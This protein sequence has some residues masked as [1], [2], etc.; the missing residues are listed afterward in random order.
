MSQENND[1]INKIGGWR[2]GAVVLLTFVTTVASSRGALGQGASDGES[3]SA[4]PPFEPAAEAS[5]TAETNP[6]SEALSITVI[7][8]KGLVQARES[9]DQPWRPATEGLQVT[10]GAEFRTG[11]RSQVV[12]FIA[13]DQTVAL[14]RLGTIKVIEAIRDDEKVK[15][16]LGMKYGRSVYDVEA[17]GVEHEAKIHMPGQTLSICG[18]RAAVFNQRPFPPQTTM[19]EGTGEHR[20][21]RRGVRIRAAAL[22][23]GRSVPAAATAPLAASVPR[24][25]L[26]QLRTL[27]FYDLDEEQLAIFTDLLNDL[28]NAAGIGFSGERPNVTV[29]SEQLNAL[30]LALQKG[31]NTGGSTYGL[32]VIEGQLIVTYPS[33]I[34][35]GLPGFGQPQAPDMVSLAASRTPGELLFELDW[36][37]TA[38]L[39]FG[40]TSPGG[41]KYCPNPAGAI[42]GCELSFDANLIEISPDAVGGPSTPH[43]ESVKFKVDHANGPYNVEVVHNIGPAT[44]FDVQV[45]RT[46][47]GQGPKPV[48][49]FS[50]SV[51]FFNNAAAQAVQ[52]SAP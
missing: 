47:S 23:A 40:V 16:D 37:T 10:Q 3:T 41:K 45:T 51:D 2:R 44:N 35:A 13:P 34:P 39:D 42:I 25:R 52:V 38:D 30:L 15:T 11:P 31:G 12:L 14:D 32:E 8:V 22:N 7:G 27:A 20:S 21:D 43:M 48:G 17:A 46:R 9:A 50:G 28:M 19:I 6:T 5:T 18:T 26:A 24:S 4:P 1:R 49:S 36:N 29:T 33:F